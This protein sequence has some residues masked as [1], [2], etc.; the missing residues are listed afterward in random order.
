MKKALA[1]KREGRSTDWV[2]FVAF[3][4]GALS[5][6]LGLTVVLGWILHS[7]FL[8]QLNPDFVPMQFNTA[9]G[10][11]LG[12]AGLLSVVYGRPR[13]AAACGAALVGLGLLT[14]T[15]SLAG[16]DLGIDQF[17]LTHDITVKTS[18][19]GRMA[20]NTALCF[21][22]FGGALVAMGRAASSRMC[23]FASGFLGSVVLT[24][25]TLAVLG[26]LLG[27]EA[28][29]GWG[30]LTR[31][32]LHTAV[33]FMLL[34]TGLFIFAWR[35]DTEGE[36]S[37]SMSGFH[38]KRFYF[39]SLIM[40]LIVTGTISATLFLLYETAF[41]QERAH[42]IAYSK[43]QAHMF[44]AV[45]Q[46]DRQYSSDDV[47]GGAFAAT[48]GQIREAHTNFSGFG[49][50]G[51][52]CLG[53][54]EGDQIKYLLGDVHNRVQHPPALPLSREMGEPMRRA[55]GGESGSLVGPDCRGITV[56]AAYEP[57]GTLGLGVVT[58]ID[59]AEI[60]APFIRAGGIAA[61]IG[62][63]LIFLGA[64]LF[65]RIGN[66]LLQ[67]IEESEA[68]YKALFAG[69]SEGLAL[70]TPEAF[71][72]CNEQ[73][74]R[75]LACER[76]DLIGHS[77]SEYFLPTQPDGGNSVAV[78]LDRMRAALSGKP[79]LY[80]W[81]QARKDGV[82]IDMEI[83][84]TAVEIDGRQLLLGSVR[85][86]T[87]RERGLE[88]IRL[89]G[90]ALEAAA[91][92]ILITDRDGNIT[93]VNT[94]FTD[95]TGYSAT[96]VVGRN[97]WILKSGK[98]EPLFY[99]ELWETILSGKTW[100][101]E[102]INLRKDGSLY[103]E[104]QT[105]TPLRD[106]HGQVTHF[107]G[108]KQ[109][110]TAR[111]Q[112][113]RQIRDIT[114]YDSL[115]GLPNRRLFQERLRGVLES[116][117]RRKRL[118]ALISIDL[119]RFKGVN[120][121]F[122]HGAGDQLLR[123]VAERLIGS[124]RRSDTITRTDLALDGVSISRMGG[125]EFTV[126]LTEIT[127]SGDAAGVAGRL[128]ESLSRRYVI[129]GRDVFSTASIGIALF[130]LDGED[131]E[132][133]MRNAD[134]AMYEAKRRGGNGWQHYASTMHTAAARDLKMEAHLHEALG[135][136]EFSLHY[137]PLRDT[138]SGRL[139]GAEA[140]LRW[141]DP[142]TGPISP[143]EF[144]PILERTGLIVS[145]GE[146][147]LRTACTQMR[148]WQDQGFRPFRLAV[149]VSGHQFMNGS[150]SETVHRILKETGLS[151]TYLEL[152][153]TESIL[154]QK[155]QRTTTELR[156]LHNGGVG[157][158]LDDFGTGYSS[159]SYLREYPF[160]RVKIDRSFVAEIETNPDDARLVAAIIA[161]A[162]RLG[163]RVVA[164][165][166]ETLEQ[167]E[168]LRQRGC[169]ELQGYLF[170]KPVPPE[171]FVHFLEKEKEDGNEPSDSSLS[172]DKRARGDDE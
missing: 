79:E 92:A 52:M 114:F 97:P 47:P 12:G 26:Y 135:R 95:L 39:P 159:L 32:A 116:A 156:N 6:A 45:G 136:H 67:Q 44:N 151:A 28:G 168:F 150:M 132:T 106:M 144:I 112:V 34:G 161:M 119:D 66:P 27:V 128:L 103:T 71:I 118:T 143:A 20:P 60:R 46:F 77:P 78:A 131:P 81:R 139:V 123:Q 130:P 43:T 99:Q 172:P 18:H 113:E 2:I 80:A 36:K 1:I 93:W 133:L 15:E 138:V 51:V 24:L 163:L 94:A 41:E 137:Q 158:A 58:K 110:I 101:G 61:S 50:T 127:D 108:V 42:L 166:V 89:Q 105:I 40:A 59:L 148:A 65:R 57:V 122:G 157:L 83:L 72:D 11:L 64:T 49:E 8:V 140:L 152:E 19:P 125:D 147:V 170:S 48:L 13:W 55:L 22:L 85:D 162:H 142:E 9:L 53:R 17:F 5:C 134:R 87:A 171:E 37:A 153:L 23:L 154:M 31:M 10:F 96:E 146:W 165:G 111:K 107:I 117:K 169:D 30:A 115:T 100:S 109:D 29:Y 38:R 129:E 4:S 7:A 160:D 90:A 73:L 82:I 126:V 3:V 84:L 149:N 69:S 75:L 167:A 120:D 54:L 25:G 145:V 86:V 88:K 164:E 56:L 68:K 62:I 91:N 124:L 74:C 35:K 21:A 14:L 104:E 121:V 33:G 98:Q 16:I 70:F 141:S 63:L 76:E 155:D 102:L